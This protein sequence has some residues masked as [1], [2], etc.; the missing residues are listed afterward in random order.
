ME[1]LIG[2][3][4]I[5]ILSYRHK[6]RNTSF[7]SQ[8]LR[9]LE[10]NKNG[11]NQIIFHCNIH[12]KLFIMITKVSWRTYLTCRKYICPEKLYNKSMKSVVKCFSNFL[13]CNCFA[14][15][16]D[17]RDTSTKEKIDRLKQL[18]KFFW[19]FTS[20]LFVEIKTPHLKK[21]ERTFRLSEGEVLSW[22]FI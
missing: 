6:K 10:S 16:K 8:G 12:G 2:S 14:C 7:V 18:L 11:F 19:A 13:T 4:V 5:E 20:R 9:L 1:N 22:Y 21:N 17:L 3:V 15:W